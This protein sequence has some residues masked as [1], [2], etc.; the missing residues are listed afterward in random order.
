VADLAPRQV[1]G[2]LLAL[3]G[4]LVALGRC[5]RRQL[6]QLALQRLQIGVDRLF[7]QALLL[8]AEVLALGRE[9]QPLEHGHL[10]RDLVDRGLLERDLAVAL[11]DLAHQRAHDFAQ[12]L[13]VQGL[14][15]RLVDHE[16]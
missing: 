4:S 11:M 12:L 9:L 3:G 6:L 10:V 7:K 15:L 1:L 2:Q 13:R 14:E 8:G 5:L 16:A